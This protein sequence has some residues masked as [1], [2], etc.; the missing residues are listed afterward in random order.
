VTLDG[1]LGSLTGTLWTDL[2]DVLDAEVLASYT[3]GFVAG[4][5]AITRRGHGTGTAT[6]VS[7]RL[8]PEGLRPVLSSVLAQAGVVSP[9]PET[10]RGRVE[11]AVR[12]GE[13]GRFLFLINRGDD[14]V[15]I[16][17]LGAIASGDA[18]LVVGPSL[19]GLDDAGDLRL[20][21]FGVAVLRAP[22]P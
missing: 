19:A 6:Y 7:T 9:L 21:P 20:G 16:E 11:P 10:M 8:G 2:L 15:T 13:Q 12:T 14:E 17:D 22:G 1:S 3:E 5:A 4:R 18:D